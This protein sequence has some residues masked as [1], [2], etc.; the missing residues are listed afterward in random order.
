MSKIINITIIWSFYF[1]AICPQLLG[2]DAVNTKDEIRNSILEDIKSLFPVNTNSGALFQKKKAESDTIIKDFLYSPVADVTAGIDIFVNGTCYLKWQDFYYR[3]QLALYS[4]SKNLRHFEFLHAQMEQQTRIYF[5]GL[6]SLRS[7]L[8]EIDIFRI[9]RLRDQYWRKV[10]ENKEELKTI[11]QSDELTQVFFNYVVYQTCLID[12]ENVIFLKKYIE[13]HGWP[14][15]PSVG[16]EMSSIAWLITQ[17]ADLDVDFQKNILRILEKLL[18]EGRIFRKNYAYLHDR[19]A[20]NTGEKQKYGT[21]IK[22]QGANVVPH[23]LISQDLV[24]AYRQ[25]MELGPL[26]E[27]LDLFTHCSETSD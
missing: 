15:L 3:Q 13:D 14:D 1:A 6:P 11:F 16:A 2:D 25:E 7:G 21:Q 10:N 24:N 17:H 18:G 5:L 26:D 4:L 19:V 22:C 8:N 9:R 20:V 12:K 27:Y 23:E